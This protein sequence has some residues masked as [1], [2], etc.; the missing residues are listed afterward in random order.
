M[1]RKHKKYLNLV[2]D[3]NNVPIYKYDLIIG[4]SGYDTRLLIVIEFTKATISGIRMSKD[5]RNFSHSSVRRKESY[6]KISEESLPEDM[7]MNYHKKV[8]SL[9]K[10]DLEA[11]KAD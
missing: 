1:D 6:F 3:D 10:K 5:S 7:R 8:E 4:Y 9:K 11:V 2:W